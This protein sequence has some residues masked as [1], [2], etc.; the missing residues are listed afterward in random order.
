MRRRGARGGADDDG[1]EAAAG[2]REMLEALRD[3]GP[4]KSDGG[5]ARCG[6]G[7]VPGASVDIRGT[8]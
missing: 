1:G 6:C 8:I 5:G 3:G 7:V 2:A 4:R